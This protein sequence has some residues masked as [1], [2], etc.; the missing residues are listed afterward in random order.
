MSST[1]PI[2]TSYSHTQ[3]GYVLIAAIGTGIA[4]IAAAWIMVGLHWAVGV[5]VAA[6]LVSLVLFVSLTVE[7]YDRRIVLRF[8]PGIVRRTISLDDVT[9]CTVV[10]NR[11]YFGWGIHLTPHG[12]LYNVSGLSAVELLM[13]NG[14]TCRIGTDEPENLAAAIRKSI[15]P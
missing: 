3:I 7:L 11:W 4:P 5:V 2:T 13:K 9:S 12:W 6:L 10:R 1:S 14:R 8:G 15:R